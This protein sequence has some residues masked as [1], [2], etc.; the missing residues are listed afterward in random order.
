ME[1]SLT[2]HWSISNS[3]LYKDSANE[4]PGASTVS[5]RAF[6]VLHEWVRPVLRPQK[7]PAAP[8]AVTLRNGAHLTQFRGTCVLPTWFVLGIFC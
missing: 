4:V 5:A 6:S 2:S 8:E 7:D 1:T 3:W